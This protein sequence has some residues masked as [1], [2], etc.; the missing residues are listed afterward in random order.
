MDV[1]V[2][3]GLGVFT[4]R[5]MATGVR[6]PNRKSCHLHGAK[7]ARRALIAAQMEH[8]N[9]GKFLRQAFAHTVGWLLATQPALDT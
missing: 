4:S 5:A 9:A 7:F 2:G 8:V 3:G 6:L 1:P